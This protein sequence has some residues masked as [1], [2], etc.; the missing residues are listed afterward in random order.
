ME[1]EAVAVIEAVHV[2]DQL[3]PY[4]GE[5]SHVGAKRKSRTSEEA[6]DEDPPSS[7]LHFLI[8]RW[9]VLFF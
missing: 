1:E 3:L 6:R 5:E 7:D 9:G 4:E 8:A 2:G